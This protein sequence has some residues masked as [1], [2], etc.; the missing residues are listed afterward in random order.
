MPHNNIEDALNQIE[1]ILR[2]LNNTRRQDYEALRQYQKRL[3]KA[4][5]SILEDQP[6]ENRGPKRAVRNK[7]TGE[8]F[9][10]IT[11]AAAKYGK[12]RSNLSFAVKH[13]TRF[14]G[15]YWEYID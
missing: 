14:Q 11:D 15:Y 12:P 3:N 5:S 2:T 13:K 6:I 9:R 1:L 7:N 10:S 4:I 8:V